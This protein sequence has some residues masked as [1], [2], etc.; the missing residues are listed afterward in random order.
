MWYNCHLIDEDQL[1][2][3]T[4][5]RGAISLFKINNYFSWTQTWKSGIHFCILVTNI[6]R[7]LL[8]I[9]IA[10]LNAHTTPINP[11]STTIIEKESPLKILL[12]LMFW[13]VIRFSVMISWGWMSYSLDWHNLR[14]S[15]M[16]DTI[17]GPRNEHIFVSSARIRRLQQNYQLITQSPASSS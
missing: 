2:I 12:I 15:S 6:N 14:L 16:T 9:T 8:T 10:N 5:K 3:R 11:K 7:Q 13:L 17:Y 4:W 1:N